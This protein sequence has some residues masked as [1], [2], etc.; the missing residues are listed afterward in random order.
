MNNQISLTG[1]GI[2][3]TSAVRLYPRIQYYELHC[4]R[5]VAVR[6]GYGRVQLNC[7]GRKYL[8]IHLNGSDLYR[9]P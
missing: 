5:K 3:T 7:D 4:V 1:R 6:L 9:R 8:R 2:Q